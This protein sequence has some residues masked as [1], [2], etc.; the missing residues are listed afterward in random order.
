MLLAY[1]PN[2]FW[3]LL[4]T[5]VRSDQDQENPYARSMLWIRL[6][7][8]LLL[9][10]PLG[11]QD[12]IPYRSG[13]LWGYSDRQKNI[14]IPCQF[15]DARFFIGDLAKV[16]QNGQ[17]GLVDLEGKLFLSCE[18]D[19]VYSDTKRGRLVVALGV[20]STGQGGKW[21]YLP[22]Y[23]GKHPDM[24]YDLIREC[25]IPYS[26]GVNQGGKWG[27]I[28]RSGKVKIPI[29]YE[30]E[31][32][33]DHQF[34]DEVL[35]ESSLSTRFLPSRTSRYLKL[36]FEQGKARVRY[37]GKWGY[38]NTF[39]NPIIPLEYDFIGSFQDGLACVVVKTSEGYKTG[40]IN[41]EN[42]FVI[43]P[44]YDFASPEYKYLQFN[45]GLVQVSRQ[46]KWGY[47]DGRNRIVVPFRYG[48][49]KSFRE[50]LA[51]VSY[52]HSYLNAPWIFINRRG[53]EIFRL[54]E[55][56]DL[57][58]YFYREGFIRVRIGEKQNW[59]N[60]QGQ[61][62][63]NPGYHEVGKFVNGQAY[64]VQKTDSG[65]YMGFVNRQGEE[66]LEPLYA[67][68]AKPGKIYQ[69]GDLF[70]LKKGKYWGM[71][72]HREREILAFVYE[73]I[74]LPTAQY[75]EDL[76]PYNLVAVKKGGKWGF[77]TPREKVAI[78]FRYEQC[79]TFRN[80]FARVKYQGRWGYIDTKGTEYFD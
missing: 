53:E 46:G 18:Y 35:L 60:Q 32:V 56:Q 3:K 55:G 59:L 71:I 6:N 75:E 24:K 33:E 48:V 37:K 27:M 15:E 66:V 9:A 10:L 12:I 49:A 45:E 65:N 13:D 25:N 40:F 63:V 36:N 19:L 41:E 4:Q 64:F 78:P 61:A 54:K 5:S 52:E 51:A 42:L 26:L 8:F 73:D 67:P 2:L 50:G 57:I 7:I 80:G 14:I 72:D 44:S 1:Q 69:V 62:L 34:E 38:I 23:R 28:N 47:V 29:Q 39:G 74:A 70:L 20:D 58:D 30:L 76:W 22:R 16:K 68:P 43:P 11:A 77:I 17:W 31:R 21:G 79:T